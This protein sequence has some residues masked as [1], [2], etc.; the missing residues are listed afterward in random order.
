M[1]LGH[2]AI[3]QFGEQKRYPIIIFLE[4]VVILFPA[5]P[6]RKTLLPPVVTDSPA[7]EP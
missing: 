2:G 5:F 6:P 4:P 3:G 1:L 7:L